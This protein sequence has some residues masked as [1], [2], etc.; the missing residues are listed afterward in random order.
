MPDA[1][2]LR[3]WDDP[4]GFLDLPMCDEDDP[5]RFQDEDEWEQ[6][7]WEWTEE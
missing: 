1:P 2:T 5:D 4:D 6:S 7:L 3:N